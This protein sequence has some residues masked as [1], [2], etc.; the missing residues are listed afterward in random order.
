MYSA[1]KRA[2]S[3]IEE[4]IL[5]IGKLDFLSSDLL[6][7]NINKCLLWKKSFSNLPNFF[8]SFISK[9]EQKEYISRLL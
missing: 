9:N 5:L 1:N 8:K 7:I 6:K 4:E 3:R 2:K